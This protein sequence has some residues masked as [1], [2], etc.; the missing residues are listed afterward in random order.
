MN[1]KS[2]LIP[3]EVPWAVSSSGSNLSLSASDNTLSQVSFE[4][5]FL[6]ESYENTESK[7]LESTLENQL[8]S[9]YKQINLFFEGVK[10]SSL[11]YAISDREVIDESAYDW[12]VVNL[13]IPSDSILE[14]IKQKK[15][16]WVKTGICP[17]PN[18][19]EVKQQTESINYK[20]YL[21]VGERA[22]V[23]IVA[24][25]WFWELKKE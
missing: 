21:I 10:S 1:N 13:G 20:H 5:C 24:Q 15:E 7:V 25:K 16:Y 6:R 19:Y 3:I 4:A 23:E 14:C 11:I 18:F 9:P 22:A 12:N 8:N 17:D 2:T